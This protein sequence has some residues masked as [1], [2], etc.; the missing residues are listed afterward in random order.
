[1]SDEVSGVQNE[2][3]QPPVVEQEISSPSSTET[4]PVE[5]EVQ[6]EEKAPKTFT[7]EEMDAIIEK[8]LAK[9]QRKAARE[10]ERLIADVMA[11][12]QQPAQQQEPQTSQ[13]PDPSQF[14][15]TEDYVEAVA[16]WKL[17]QKLAAKN[18][19]QERVSQERV[20]EQ[21]R[22]EMVSEYQERVEQAIAKYDDYEEVTTNPALK[23]SQPMADA[24]IASEVGPDVAYYL[25]INPKEADRIAKLPP[26][27][28]VK[29]IGRLEAKVMAD[30]PAKKTTSAPPP[31]SPVKP[32]GSSPVTDTLN[33]K[34]LE[35]LGT[36]EWIRREEQRLRKKW[37]AEHR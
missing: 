16:E 19:E 21:H 1:M 14:S 15:T 11:R 33:P 27:L 34:S 18:Q 23:I 8:R 35:T 17:E 36:S 5:S 22:A 28:Q 25:G 2:L 7:Q 4:A 10:R 13:R 37:E 20:I 12:T 31:I 3:A 26:F 32:K 6:P 29:E 9:E 24:I 30:P